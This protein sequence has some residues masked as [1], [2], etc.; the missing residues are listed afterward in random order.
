MLNKSRIN[1]CCILDKQAFIQRRG[2]MHLFTKN[3]LWCIDFL[4]MLPVVTL[5]VVAEKRHFY[6]WFTVNLEKNIQ[7]RV[8]TVQLLRVLTNSSRF[9]SKFY[10]N[11]WLG[12][13][14][15]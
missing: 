10:C 1:F 3:D 7:R 2:G 11:I 6:R 12:D 9:W 15:K 5:T 8:F 13:K 14:A 4:V